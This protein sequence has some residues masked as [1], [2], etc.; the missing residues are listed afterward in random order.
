MMELCRLTS[1]RWVPACSALPRFPRRGR[2]GTALVPPPA[3][4]FG[5][6][7]R[8]RSGP[9][10]DP[11]RRGDLYIYVDT[12]FYS[13]FFSLYLFFFFYVMDDDE[14]SCS[15]SRMAGLRSPT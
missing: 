4:R 7:P 8:W 12:V 3:I 6:R 1:L 14:M 13:V 2:L 11:F 5:P 10:R 15:G 9:R